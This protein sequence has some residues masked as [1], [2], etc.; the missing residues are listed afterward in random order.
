M[1]Y[2][3]AILPNAERIVHAICH[4]IEKNNAAIANKTKPAMSQ[5]RLLFKNFIE[6]IIDKRQASNNKTNAKGDQPLHN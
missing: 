6:C 2:N 4:F 5:K 1:A 3:E